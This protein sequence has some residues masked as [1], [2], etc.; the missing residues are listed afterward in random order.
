MNCLQT[1]TIRILKLSVCLLV[2]PGLFC[3]CRSGHKVVETKSVTETASV[4]RETIQEHTDENSMSS[5][6][7]TD[8]ILNHLDLTLDFERYDY[9]VVVDTT[10]LSSDMHGLNSD[11]TY[12]IPESHPVHVTKGSIRLKVAGVSDRSFTT[13]SETRRVSTDTTETLTVNQHFGQE[14]AVMQTDEQ[15]GAKTLDPCRAKTWIIIIILLAVT[16]L[17]LRLKRKNPSRK[18]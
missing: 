11:T 17:A 6:I 4:C 18:E 5:R 16:I 14:M 13:E 8:Y 10:L 9:D 1:N 12:V 2:W 7:L 15:S 3:G